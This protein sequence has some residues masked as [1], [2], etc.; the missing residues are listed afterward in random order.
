MKLITSI[1]IIIIIIIIIINQK[2]V[3]SHKSIWKQSSSKGRRDFHYG[4]SRHGIVLESNKLKE[5]IGKDLKIIYIAFF[6]HLVE[7]YC[8]YR[9]SIESESK[10]TACSHHLRCSCSMSYCSETVCFTTIKNLSSYSRIIKLS[11]RDV[12]PHRTPSHP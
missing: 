7:C 10:M 11:F 3:F 12:A 5:K 8:R 4:F 9:D 2:R 6:L 1:K